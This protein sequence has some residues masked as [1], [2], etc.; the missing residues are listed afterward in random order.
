MPF[1]NP[2]SVEVQVAGDE[3]DYEKA[4][5]IFIEIATNEGCRLKKRSPRS[6]YARCE[7]SLPRHAPPFVAEARSPRGRRAPDDHA[8]Q[9][10]TVTV[11]QHWRVGDEG[12][13]ILQ[14]IREAFVAEFGPDRI[15]GPSKFEPHWFWQYEIDR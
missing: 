4:M 9:V 3:A 15:L 10:F 12:N 7:Y 1:S 11:S 2:S 6:A 5:Q 14:K 13:R 8:T